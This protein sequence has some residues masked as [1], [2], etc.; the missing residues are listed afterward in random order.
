[1]KKEVPIWEKYTITIE[2][3]SAYFEIGQKKLREIIA[4]HTDSGLTVMN[5]SKVLIKRKAFE[6][7]LTTIDVI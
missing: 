6:N 2:E 5:G 3:A 7:F 1:M 4:N